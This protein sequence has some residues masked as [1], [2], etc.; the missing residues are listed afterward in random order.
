MCDIEFVKK[1]QKCL[2]K[3][4]EKLVKSPLN[5]AVSMTMVYDKDKTD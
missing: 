4:W 3:K 5:S 2:N 1:M